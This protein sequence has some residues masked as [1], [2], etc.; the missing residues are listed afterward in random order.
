[1]IELFMKKLG[2]GKIGLAKADRPEAYNQLPLVPS[3]RLLATVLLRGPRSGS[4]RAFPPNTRLLGSAAALLQYNCLCGAMAPSATRILKIPVMGYFEDF[5]MA[6]P[7]PLTEDAL[8]ASTKMS[9]ILGFSL[10]LSKSERGQ[11]IEFL[12]LILDI[13]HFPD[14]PPT[15]RVSK[16]KRDKLVATI[17]AVSGDGKV[18]QAALQKLLGKLAVTQTATM[19]KI[20]RALLRPLYVFVNSVEAPR[21]LSS[22]AWKS[23][24]R[25]FSVL[26][27]LAPRAIHLTNSRPDV[28]IFA[29]AAG[30]G[31]CAAF[32]F[33]S[34][35]EYS[36]P[37][38]LIGFVS[39]EDQELA[40]GANS[41][42]VVGSYGRRGSFV[43][44]A[45]PKRKQSC[46]PRR[47]RCCRPGPN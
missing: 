2:C 8:L 43:S 30:P 5:G 41:I 47:Q 40:G 33:F 27:R 12:G 1:M 45:F 26:P 14:S 21:R 44:S 24:S 46:L 37:L 22:A 10:E 23:L 36:K 4:W 3:R 25:R 16:L 34:E 9:E 19:G 35:S 7:L 11:I 38:L 42:F 15:L 39:K 32:A 18:S 17:D 6:S 31:G 28:L 13:A 29:N 20:G